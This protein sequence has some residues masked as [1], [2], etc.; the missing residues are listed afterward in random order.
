MSNK[1]DVPG[2]IVF[3]PLIPLVVLVVGILLDWLV[4]LGFLAA[5]PLSVRVVA[6]LAGVAFGLWAL[7]S[8]RQRFKSIGTNVNPFEPSLAIAHDGIYSPGP[9]SNVCRR[10]NG[11]ARRGAVVWLAAAGYLRWSRRFALS[12]LYHIL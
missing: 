3:P 8:A 10:T 9:Q 1:E 7:I 4:P 6:G 11:I 12:P 2:V 5:I